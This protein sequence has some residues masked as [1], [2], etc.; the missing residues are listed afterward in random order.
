MNTEADRLTVTLA[1]AGGEVINL[2]RTN[3]RH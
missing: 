1:A 3:P 2:A